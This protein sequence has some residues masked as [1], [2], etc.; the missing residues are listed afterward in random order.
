MEKALSGG[1]AGP[2]FQDRV[3]DTLA[4]NALPCG[5]EIGLGLV[6]GYASGVALRTVGRA[7]A[8]FV[9]GSFIFIQSLASSGYIQVDWKK[10]ESSY[11]SLLDVDEDGELREVS[12]PLL[13]A[14]KVG[15]A[16]IALGVLGRGAVVT[17]AP[18]VCTRAV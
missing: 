11:K 15:M 2:S 10:V 4:E 1:S 7:L 17:G 5:K 16:G 12:V 6:M 13:P 18:A 3:K 14:G 8:V 9:G